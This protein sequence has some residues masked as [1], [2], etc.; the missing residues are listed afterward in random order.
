MNEFISSYA[1][2]SAIDDQGNLILANDKNSHDDKVLEYIQTGIENAKGFLRSNSAF[3][4]AEVCMSI[5]RGDSKPVR[6]TGPSRLQI[7]KS[8]RQAREAIANQSDIRQNWKVRTLKTEDEFYQNQADRLNDLSSNWWFSQFVDRTIKS[9]QQLAGGHGTGY[10]W[11]YPDYDSLTGEIDIIPTWLDYKQVLVSHIPKDGDIYKAYRV[12]I[13]F[14]YPL[15]TAHKKFPDHIDLLVADR[16]KPSWILRGWEESKRKFEGIIKWSQKRNSKKSPISANPFPSCDVFYTFIMDEQINI[17]GK[18]IC[19]GGDPLAHWYY[20]VPS[21]IDKDG[22]PNTVGTNSFSKD[23]NGNTVETL[24]YLTRDECKL[25][26]NRRLIISCS[27]GI[28]YDGPPK[29]GDGL[30]PVVQFYFEKIVG[31]FLGISPI[32][33]TR[34]INDSVENIFRSMEDMAVGKVDPP[35]GVDDR[36]PKNIVAD[37]KKLGARGLIGKVFNYSVMALQKAIVPLIGSEYYTIDTAT[38]TLVQA[39]QSLQDYSA[40]TRDFDNA[41]RL[42]QMPS[43]DTQEA[44]VEN[45]GT[46]TT[47]QSREQ[48]RSFMFLGRLWLSFAP[49]VYTLKRRLQI[50]PTKNAFDFKELDFD[51]SSIAPKILENDSRPSWIRMKEH[52]KNFSIFVSPNSIQERQSY[53]NK[54]TLLQVSKLGVPISARKIYDTLVGDDEYDKCKAEYYAE[55]EEKAIAAAKIQGEVQSIMQAIQMKNQQPSNGNQ[56]GQNPIIQDLLTHLGNNMNPTN[57]EGRPSSNEAAPK[58]ESKNDEDGIKRT[59]LATS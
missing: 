1:P 37:I 6:S 27:K 12:D 26:P 50:L 48:E 21:Y 16:G 31:E 58:V 19:M 34:S 29:W 10:C 5:L 47:D 20:E 44:M 2:P 43:A 45:L 9:V 33:D 15:P 41:Q 38:F 30:P 52:V 56:Q 53:T 54:L 57:S 35:I 17:T 7:N 23:V 32:N 49:Q 3:K 28:L 11:L 14:E 24:R 25:Y 59:T 4:S 40:G 18:T 51:P 39:L 13:R 42:K 8:R 36:T 22:N 46:L 55:Q